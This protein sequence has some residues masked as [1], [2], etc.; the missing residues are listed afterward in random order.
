MRPIPK[1]VLSR[2]FTLIEMLATL[3]ILGV[4]ASMVLPVAQV[5][6]QRSKE[7]ELRTS[8]REIRQAIDAYK[9]AYD[10]GRVRR[11]IGGTGYPKSLDMLVEG[12]EDQSDPK[13][14][15]MYFMR[16]LP[17]DPLDTRPDVAAADTWGKR[18]YASDAADPLEGDDVYDVYSLSDKV[19]LNNVAYK[20]W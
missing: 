13:H 11:E 6:V 15:K 18:S 12:V 9:R 7:N 2:G 17:R 10:G 1:S 4:L 16:R 20:R 8:L 14:N 5:T 3:A 19:G